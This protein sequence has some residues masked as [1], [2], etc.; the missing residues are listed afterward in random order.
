MEILYI[1]QKGNEHPWMTD[2]IEAVGDRATVVIYDD[3]GP[4]AEQFEGVDY[5][6]ELGGKVATH[7]MIDA[8][9]AAGITFW[10]IQGTGMDHVDIP[11]FEKKGIQI[12]N[13]PGQFSS[14]AL[15]EHAIYFTRISDLE[16]RLEHG[17][18]SLL[19]KAMTLPRKAGHDGIE[20]YSWPVLVVR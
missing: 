8:A 7:E 17:T 11:Y 12:A 13:T 14:I 19:L 1:P 15:A 5:V 6:V 4:I 9:A 16:L 2:F 18:P 10:Q 3:T 20:G